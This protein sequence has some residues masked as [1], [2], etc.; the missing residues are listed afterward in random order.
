MKHELADSSC[1]QAKLSHTNVW[2]AHTHSDSVCCLIWLLLPASDEVFEAVNVGLALPT[3]KVLVRRGAGALIISPAG[4][5]DLAASFP[6]SIFTSISLPFKLGWLA[7]KEQLASCTVSGVMNSSSLREALCSYSPAC[8]LHSNYPPTAM[9]GFAS[10][11][12][13][14]P[15]YLQAVMWNTWRW[16]I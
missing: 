16:H 3:L 13:I 5:A 4:S 14:T 6:P 12:I 2:Y 7:A 15:G 1:T 9:R 8:T 11:H 10:K